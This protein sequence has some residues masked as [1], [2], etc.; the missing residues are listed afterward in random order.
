MGGCGVV[1][2]PWDSMYLVPILPV[3]LTEHRCI[4][5]CNLKKKQKTTDCMIII[6][7]LL[8]K[9]VSTFL[10]NNNYKKQEVLAPDT[11]CLMVTSW[12]I[13]RQSGHMTCAFFFNVYCILKKKKKFQVCILIFKLCTRGVGGDKCDG[14][15]VAR[16]LGEVCS[17]VEK[18]AIIHVWRRWHLPK[19]RRPRWRLQSWQD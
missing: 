15:I 12:G 17:V 14:R 5:K 3:W 18:P 7:Y 16:V 6:S 9:N 8:F 10:N 2:L 4:L 11:C 19:V 13:I 1:S